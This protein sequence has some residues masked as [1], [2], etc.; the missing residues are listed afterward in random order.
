MKDIMGDEKAMAEFMAKK[1]KYEALQQEATDRMQEINA[2][3]DLL[4]G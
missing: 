4:K 2:A 1:A 3:W